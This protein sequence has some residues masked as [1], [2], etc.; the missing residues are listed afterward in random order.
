MKYIHDYAKIK[1]GEEKSFFA[2]AVL[3]W[4]LVIWAVV[5]SVVAAVA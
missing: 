3:F 4:V 1:E 5:Y 2:L